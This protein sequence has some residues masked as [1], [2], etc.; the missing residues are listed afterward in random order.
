MRFDS[1]GS[2][3][4][5]QRV[6]DCSI[7]DPGR[8][9]LAKDLQEFAAMSSLKTLATFFVIG[10]LPTVSSAGIYSGHSDTANAIDPGIEASDARFVSWANIIDATQT[11]FGPRGSSSINQS[12]GVNS[13]GDLSASEIAN[14]DAPG[15]LTAMFPIGIFNGAGHDFA[16]FENGFA[17]FDDGGT[18]I[19]ESTFLFAELAYVDVSSNGIDF[20]RFD[21]TATNEEADLYTP[22]GRSFAGIDPTNVHNLAGKHA[23]GFGTP[24]DLDELSSDPLVTGGLVDLNNIQFVRL[25]DI[26]GNGA[27]LDA[28]G[29]PILDTWLT[30]GSTGGFDFQLGVGSGIGVINAVPEPSSLAIL[31]LAGF[32]FALRK[33][34][35][36]LCRQ[37]KTE[38]KGSDSV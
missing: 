17:F 1:G 21:S 2:F 3:F 19:D 23:A 18:P 11:M 16:V 8:L 7:R 10:V 20:A 30:T 22:F 35:L 24:F 4:L 25:T 33:K 37:S 26:P 27:F 6:T 9:V 12:G 38:R 5:D 28:Q 32:A 15:I 34:T 36:R 29:N 13:L 31:C 14:G